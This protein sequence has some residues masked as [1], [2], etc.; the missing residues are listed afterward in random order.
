MS[1]IN[2]NSELKVTECISLSLDLKNQQSF[3]PEKI[4]HN[5]N[6]CNQEN[7]S[8]NFQEV[9]KNLI[10]KEKEKEN[11]NNQEVIAAIENNNN[12][13]SNLFM[14]PSMQYNPVLCKKKECNG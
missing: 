11:T 2:Y 5:K 13:S 4:K 7:N 1:M 8:E 3:I 10:I 14:L 12:N 6:S 9:L